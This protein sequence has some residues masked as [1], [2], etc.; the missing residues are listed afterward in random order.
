MRQ[1]SLTTQRR[2]AF[3]LCASYS[4]VCSGVDTEKI[5]TSNLP[6]GI[7]PTIIKLSLCASLFFTFPVMLFPVSELMDKRFLTKDAPYWKGNMMRAGLVS[8]AGIVA[9]LVPDFAIIMGFIGSTCCMLLALIM[10]ALLHLRYFR[11]KLSTFQL[12]FDYYVLALG[13]VCMVSGTLDAFQR[14]FASDSDDASNMQ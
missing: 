9:L 7:F 2:L 8:T 3:F 6:P 12:L 14:L 1:N 4:Y 11:K 13:I 5:I 10:P